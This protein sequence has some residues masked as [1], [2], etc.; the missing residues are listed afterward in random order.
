VFSGRKKCFGAGDQRG[1]QL[2]LNRRSSKELEDLAKCLSPA[3]RRRD[4]L[5]AGWVEV[6][7]AGKM[8]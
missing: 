5:V 2:F 8:K 4:E 1:W 6:L 7:R 3:G